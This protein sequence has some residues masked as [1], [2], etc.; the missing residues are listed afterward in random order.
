MTFPISSLE[1]HRKFWFWVLYAVFLWTQCPSSESS[2]SRKE[3]LIF[4]LTGSFFN[5]WL[6]LYLS[7]LYPRRKGS[8]GENWSINEFS[9]SYHDAECNSWGCH[10]FRLLAAGERSTNIHGSLKYGPSRN[11]LQLRN[12]PTIGEHVSTLMM[13]FADANSR[14]LYGTFSDIDFAEVTPAV[15]YSR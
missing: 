8:S 15:G 12:K 9:G 13:H 10:A 11:D 14:L 5:S 2:E 3:S 6:N 7:S 1:V 4:Y